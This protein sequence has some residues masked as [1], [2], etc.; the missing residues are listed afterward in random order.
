MDGICIPRDEYHV[1]Q[2][3]HVSIRDTTSILLS[4]LSFQT[5]HHDNTKERE[6]VKESESKIIDTSFDLFVKF[7]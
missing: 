2:Y 7:T 3:A 1:D 4:F 5:C 6:K